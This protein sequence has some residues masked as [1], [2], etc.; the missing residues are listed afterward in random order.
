MAKQ[1]WASGE[2]AKKMAGFWAVCGGVC[3]GLG[4]IFAILGIIAEATS[5]ILGL[6]PLSWYMLTIALFAAS[7]VWYIGWAVGVLYKK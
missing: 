1:K 7:I 3:W 4:L 5:N 2:R 6:T